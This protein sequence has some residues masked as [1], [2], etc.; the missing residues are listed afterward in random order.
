MDGLRL[1]LTS[2]V[3]RTKFLIEQQANLYDNQAI[4][5]ISG[6]PSFVNGVMDQLKELGI[7][8]SHIKYDRFTGY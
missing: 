2:G 1:E 7:S 6:S 3:V 8:E 5:Y 4:Y